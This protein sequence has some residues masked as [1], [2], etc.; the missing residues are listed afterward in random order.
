[1]SGKILNAINPPATYVAPG[2]AIVS[3]PNRSNIAL[4]LDYTKG[5]ETSIE[6]RVEK[7][8]KFDTDGSEVWFQETKEDTSVNPSTFALKERT[9][10][11]SGKY[12][13]EVLNNPADD[14]VR[15]SVKRTGGTG[16]GVVTL[17]CQE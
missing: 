1:M 16:T 4:Y 3:T 13:L 15:F 2:I 17:Y 7:S 12:R 10:T 9:F 8:N 11:A 14:K 6:L 5:D